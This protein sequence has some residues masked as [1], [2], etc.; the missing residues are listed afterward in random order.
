MKNEDRMTFHQRAQEGM[1]RKFDKIYPKLAAKLAEPP[2]RFT[3]KFEARFNTQLAGRDKLFGRFRPEHLTWDESKQK[4]ADA[5]G[6]DYARIS[7][8][9]DSIADEA[10]PRYAQAFHLHEQLQKRP[11]GVSEKFYREADVRE[12][13]AFIY[14]SHLT[15]EFDARLQTL[16]LT[17]ES[18]FRLLGQIIRNSIGACNGVGGGTAY[19]VHPQPLGFHPLEVEMQKMRDYPTHHAKP[20][21]EKF[22]A[23]P[24][25]QR[26]V[27]T[28]GAELLSL[29]TGRAPKNHSK[30]HTDR[31]KKTDGPTQGTYR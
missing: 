23:I 3:S 10:G 7:D 18:A 9:L 24:K 26:H 5:S 6:L 4:A 13:F 1:L 17:D 30:H 25:D 27:P 28:I 2:A 15:N 19:D 21:Y 8:A 16:G 20:L 22:H 11:R 31:L 12:S 29:L 14:K